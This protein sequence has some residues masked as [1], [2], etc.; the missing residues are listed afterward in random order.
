MQ[1]YLLSGLRLN[2]VMIQPHSPG[3]APDRPDLGVW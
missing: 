2:A 3:R 1:M